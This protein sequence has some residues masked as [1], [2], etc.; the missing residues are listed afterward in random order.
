MSN[1]PVIQGMAEL[2]KRLQ[3]AAT[4]L[5]RLVGL[6]L[7][8]GANAIAA[9]AKQRAPGDQGILR[10]LISVREVSP[11][12]FEVVSGADY[13]AFV[14]FGT[15]EKVQIPPGL[16]EYAAQ[17]KG[18]FASGTYSEGSGLTAKEAIFAW[19]QR[20]GIDPKLWYPIYVS[21]MIHGTQPQPFFF[22]AAE[23]ITPIIIDRVEKVL[24]NI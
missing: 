3:D 15:G 12:V 17:F 1:V 8:D 6:E 18:D 16:E 14:E 9:E 7:K 20:K 22:P 2:R 21:I 10:N 23:R 24:S 13:S 11:T 19:C 5:P 4:N